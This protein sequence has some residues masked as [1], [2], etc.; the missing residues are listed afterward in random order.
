M[1]NMYMYDIYNTYDRGMYLFDLNIYSI[2][3]VVVE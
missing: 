1:Y 2:L 3:N